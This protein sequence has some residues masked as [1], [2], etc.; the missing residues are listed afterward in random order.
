MLAG[1]VSRRLGRDKALVVAGGESLAARAARKLHTQSGEVIA[2]DGGRGVVPGVPSVADGSGKGPVAGV[3]GAASAR[4]G[5]PLLVL[6]C[7]LPE[8]PVPLLAAL[9]GEKGSGRED[10][11]WV[12]PRW[13]GRLEP[14][15]AFYAPS[16]LAALARRVE[17][18]RFAPHELAE[19]SGL[20]IR[21][22]E[23]AELAR[24]GP[25][26]RLFLNL[27]TP[28]DLARWLG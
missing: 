18:G 15:C 24:F 12:V 26:E 20:S 28:D 13:G 17:E 4:S 25:P 9:L 14:L 6:A 1:G 16:A 27:N 8:V 21:F 5:H 22:L 10:A 3:L 11:D 2:A 7:D 19:E 23:D